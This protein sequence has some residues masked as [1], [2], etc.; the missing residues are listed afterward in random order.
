MCG[1][2]VKGFQKAAGN[3]VL[4]CLR[5]VC[6]EAGSTYVVNSHPVQYNL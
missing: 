6:S 4:L 1:V 2:C 5:P 3:G